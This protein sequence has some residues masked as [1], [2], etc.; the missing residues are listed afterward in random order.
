MGNDFVYS[1]S[2]CKTFVCREEGVERG[3]R[4]RQVEKQDTERQE[5]KSVS[6]EEGVLQNLVSILFPVALNL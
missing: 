5:N 4:G 3:R 1:F 6:L 2:C